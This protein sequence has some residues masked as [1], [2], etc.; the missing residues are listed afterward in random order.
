MPLSANPL[1]M[2]ARNFLYVRRYNSQA[3]KKVADNKLRTKRLL[4]SNKIPTTR[5]IKAFNS[6]DAVRT[7]DWKLPESGFVV[8]PA[9]GY[10]GE[11]ILVFS[12]WKGDRGRTISG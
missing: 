10:G 1:G 3:A 6:R 12:R 9:R 5:L 8:K 7:F 11:G 2:N 4:L